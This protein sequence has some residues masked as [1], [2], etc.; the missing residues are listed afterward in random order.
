MAEKLWQD[1]TPEEKSAFRIDKWRHPDMTFASLQAEADYKARVDRFV[2]AINLEK[3]D[4][5]PIHIQAG[6][7]PAARAGLTPYEAMTDPARA[8]EAWKKFHL[9]FQPDAFIAPFS[10]AF[11]AAVPAALDYK[12]YSW[13]GHGTAHHAG[14]QYNEKEW[15]LPDEY[16][17]LISDP[18]D[19]LLRTYLPRAMGAFSGFAGLSPFLDFVELPFVPSHVG[20]W[21]SEEMVAGLKGITK[22]AEEAAAWGS[23][24]GPAMGEVISLGYPVYW[25]GATKAPFDILG[26]TLRGTRGIIMDIFRRPEKVLAACERLVQVAIDWH[27]R[28]PG[29]PSSPIIIMPLHKGADGF[30]SDEQFRTFYWPTLRKVLLGLIDEG[31][32]PCLFAE[33]KYG[34][35]LEVIMDLPKGKTIWLFDQTD[36]ARAKATI[37]QVACIQGNVPLSL[38][39]AGTPAKVTDYCRRL[40]DAAAD[41]GGFIMDIGAI[42]DDGKDE[43]LRAMMET[44]R[45]YGVY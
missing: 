29:F 38:I 22:A 36:M 26:D 23:V 11:S 37:G 7:L 44:T 39:Y 6:F 34:S 24:M 15:M 33:G 17:H 43:N 16:D 2:A 20:G 41:G 30:M 9:D 3:A 42:A 25:A 32:I 8:A 1:M 14:F 27:L 35:R 10:Y 19:Y 40:L 31:I 45:G 21:G 13:P 18:T 28:R 4:R 12:L 5:V